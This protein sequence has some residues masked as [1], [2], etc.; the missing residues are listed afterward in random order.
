MAPGLSKK[1][2]SGG[3]VAAD[4]I[5]VVVQAPPKDSIRKYPP[6][7]LCSFPGG[8]PS[9]LHSELDEELD[10]TM[11]F[12]W[13]VDAS[14]QQKILFGKDSACSYTAAQV[15]EHGSTKKAP[16]SGTRV[17]VGIYDKETKTVT[18]HEVSGNGHVYPM[19]QTVTSYRGADTNSSMSLAERR[20]ALFE[21]FGSAKK[22]KTI[23]SQEAN[24]VDVD[25]VVGAGKL[26]VDS[27]LK[28]ESMSESNKRAIEDRKDNGEGHN[29]NG[30]SKAVEEATLAWRKDFLP[31][32]NLKATV[33]GEVY[34]AEEIVGGAKVWQDLSSHV[35]KCL[36]KENVASA[37]IDGGRWAEEMSSKTPKEERKARSA[38]SSWSPSLIALVEKIA[39]RSSKNTRKQL[40]CAVAL[41][42]MSRLYMTLSKRKTIPAPRPPKYFGVP[43]TFGEAWVARFAS[44]VLNPD[45][46]IDNYTMAK[47]S[48]E[49][50]CLNLLLLLLFA[51][52]GDSVSCADIIPFTL[53]LKMD[54]RETS[55]LLRSAGC[56]VKS[57][58]GKNTAMSAKLTVPLTF[59][60]ISKRGQRG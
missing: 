35:S 30:I 55:H 9:T 53:D 51:D 11:N 43:L 27:V 47:A 48:K 34:S 24:R 28:G 10:E 16:S 6:P 13:R 38:R 44:E 26:V 18:L 49:K 20:K 3:G 22:R 52:G 40:V 23:R 17:C 50:C 2:K 39:N 31:T 1:R 37:I 56:T 8:L 42:Y 19:M 59:P 15:K 58:S 36:E 29:K 57:S 33:P 32:F 5:K 60:K 4:E 46:S 21:D 45:G 25:S 41:H 7:V 12:Q 14:S 54:T